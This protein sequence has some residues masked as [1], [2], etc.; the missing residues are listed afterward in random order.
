MLNYLRARLLRSLLT[1]FLVISFTFI[2]LRLTG[3]P[4]MMI[5]S[6]DAPP[7]AIAAFRATWGLDTPLWQQFL[8]Y[9]WNIVQGNFGVSMR[10]GN[11]AMG[12]VLEA[13]PATLAI[14]IPAFVL[15][16]LLGIPAG[17]LAAL[18]RNSWIDRLLMS[19]AVAG[20][21][22]PSF[23]LGLLLVLLFA[24]RLGWLPSGGFNSPGHVILPIITLTISGAA[25]LARYT[26][27]S[28]LEVLGQPYVRAAIAKGLTYRQVILR[29]AL[30]NAGMPIVTIAGLMMGGLIAG[31]VV[32][33]NVF[34]WPGIGRLMVSAV[35]NRDLAVVQAALLL[36]TVAMI[37][38]NLLVDAIYGLIDPR[39]RGGSGGR[40][41]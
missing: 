18:Y 17:V 37:S 31:A 4:A 2:I 13:A 5:L 38:A 32:V 39:V 14:T 22:L 28:M 7:E 25:V 3:D 15:K 27:S 30:P 10:N 1:L 8:G 41:S 36:I 23:V 19:L 24:V 35:G 9:L 26:R 16:I 11:S 20:H 12:L 21:T 6:P 29:H 40:K 34:S 33:E